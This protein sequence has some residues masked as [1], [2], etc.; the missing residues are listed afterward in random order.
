[1]QRSAKKN[2]DNNEDKNQTKLS[3]KKD[4]SR[5]ASVTTLKDNEPRITEEL[6]NLFVRRRTTIQV[7]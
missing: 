6:L 1:M 5:Y 2:T 3:L 4:T 7:R